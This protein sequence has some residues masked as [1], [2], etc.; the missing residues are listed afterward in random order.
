M[1]AGL[2]GGGV[3]ER[4]EDRFLGGEIGFEVLV[5]DGGA[6]MPEP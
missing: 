6:G 5:R 1:E 3:T 2:C 4:L